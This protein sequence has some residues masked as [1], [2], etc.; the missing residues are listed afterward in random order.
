MPEPYPNEQRTHFIDRCMMDQESNQSFPERDQRYAFCNSQ[1]DNKKKMFKTIHNPASVKD[2]DISSRTVTGYFASFGNLDSDGDVFTPGAF[3]K[4]ISE[5]GPSGANR[6]IHLLQHDTLK[7]LGKPDILFEDSAGLYFET[8]V[9]K[10]TYGDDVLK[11]YETGT[12]NEHS[13]GFV[14]IDEER[15]DET[16]NIL[17]EVKLYEGSTVTWGANEATPFMGFKSLDKGNI[18]DRLEKLSKSVSKGT[19]TDD[20]LQLLEIEFEQLKSLLHEGPIE[21]ITPDEK[22]DQ[23]INSFK[24]QFTFL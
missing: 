1:F 20:T 16:T 7:P 11:L 9:A 5:R 19:F 15:K 24:N 12:F 22:A 6:I 2:V 23:L 10:T 13:V 21:Q 14:T 8:K 4:T 3:K 18:T 17:K